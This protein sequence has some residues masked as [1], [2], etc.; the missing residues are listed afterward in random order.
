MYCPRARRYRPTS[1]RSPTNAAS[2]RTSGSAPSVTRARYDDGRWHLT[3]AAGE[4]T[5]DV[6]VAATGVLRVPRYPD[7]PGWESFSGP[8]FHSS[9]WDHSVSLPDKRI[10]IIGTG[11]TGVQIVAALG[12]NVRQLTLFQRSAQWI[13]P[14]PNPRYTAVGKWALRRWPALNKIGYAFW[15]SYIRVMVGR[16]PIRPGLQR[17]LFQAACRWNLRRSVR[18][19]A[20]RAKL[21]P[22]DQPMCKR[23]ILA[24][25]FYRAAQAPGVEVITDGIDHIEERGVVT[26]DGALHE[27]DMLVFATGFDARAFLRP[28]EVVGQGGKSLDEAWS[29]GPKAYRSVAVPGFPNFFLMM[30]PH[31]PIGNQSLIPVAEDQ[32]DYALWWIQRLREGSL[33]SAA[34][35]EAATKAYNEAMKAAFPQTI[36]VSGCSSWYLGK[37]GLPELFPWNTGETPRT[38]ATAGIGRFRRDVM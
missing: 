31:S 15:G 28:M 27:L 19:P 33:R 17:R 20:L 35:T 4:E 30:G 37:D 32:A 38:A 36:W 5:F 25:H 9:R 29:D 1:G 18:D 8:A 34:P 21:T 11:S 12:G 6:L 26:A 14:S 22:K 16:A 7:I 24:G 13:F 3:T 23:L 2:A 10:G